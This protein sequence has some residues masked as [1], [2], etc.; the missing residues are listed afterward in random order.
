[1][2]KENEEKEY[3]IYTGKERRRSELN[4]L[5]A[6]ERLT[7]AVEL[8]AEQ[9]SGNRQI[10]FGLQEE[11]SEL[12]LEIQ[13]DISDLKESL[14]AAR[15]DYKSFLKGYDKQI[16]QYDKIHDDHESRIRLTTHPVECRN[17]KR[18][19]TLENENK[20]QNKNIFKMAGILTVLLTILTIFLQWVLKHIQ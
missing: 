6:M 20:G 12:K 9:F 4:R 14:T 8:L 11:M 10:L 19:E 1:M 3:Q 16:A 13:T 17:I 15:V 2:N 7:K 5:E 18:I